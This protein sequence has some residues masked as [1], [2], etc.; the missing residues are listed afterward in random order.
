M[1]VLL[2]ASFMCA[3][4]VVMGPTPGENAKDRDLMRRAEPVIAA[5][6]KFH[7]VHGHYSRKL[8]ELV[9]R[10][11]ADRAALSPYRYGVWKGEYSLDFSYVTGIPPFQRITQCIYDPKKKKWSCGGYM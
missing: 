2:G 5:V 10:Y 6:E 3:C 9:P 1:T 7:A 11:I 8:D 4:Q